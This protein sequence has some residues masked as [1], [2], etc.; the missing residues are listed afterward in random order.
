MIPGDLI[1]S[2]RANVKLVFAT[3][4]AA[5][6][7][8]L[9]VGVSIT[10]AK[11]GLRT[12]KADIRSLERYDTVGE[13]SHGPVYVALVGGR[14]PNRT[15][16]VTTPRHG[17][18]SASQVHVFEDGETLAGVTVTSAGVGSTESWYLVRYMSIAPTGDRE[19]EATIAVDGV[20]EAD[21][22]YHSPP[23]RVAAAAPPV[24]TA[25]SP[26]AAAPHHRTQ[27][28]RPA[29]SASPRHA[30]WTSGLGLILV[31]LLAAPLVALA[32]LAFL[33]PRRRR[34]ELRRRVADFTIT[35]P[36]EAVEIPDQLSSSRFPALQRFLERMSWWPRFQEHVEIA[37]LS[38]SAIELVVIT[39]VVTIVFVVLAGAVVGAPA[40]G[41]IFL[42]IG[43]FVLHFVVLSR[44]RKQQELFGEQLAPHLEELASAMRAGHGLASGLAAM[45]KSATEPS[46][47]EWGRVVADEQLGRSLDTAMHSMGT[48]MDCPDVE[49]VALVAALH[50]QTGGNMAEVL[51]RVAEGVR[52]RTELRRELKALTA[53]A[54]LSRWVVSLLPPVLIGIITA[55]D[56]SYM[57]PLF[58][59]RGGIIALVVAGVLLACGSL[60]M[61]AVTDIKV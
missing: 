12:R 15:V 4:A 54:R 60:A 24:R 17:A 55:I 18:L 43:P 47:G 3:S 22:D 32:L 20:G 38:H 56:P 11:S 1:T 14:F 27:P 23:A 49:Q 50:G 36:S 26:P 41:L 31:S 29:Q 42:P 61:R 35:T 46:R 44:A 53:Q 40:A 5:L 58:T 6:M 7:L 25:G 16:R 39:A 30:F 33:V 37:R 45:A 2:R 9:A 34:Q 48:R 57:K 10:Q 21:F 13:P 59:T 8:A 28:V 51:E 52:E 19:V